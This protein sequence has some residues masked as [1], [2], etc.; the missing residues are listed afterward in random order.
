MT[1]AR[2]FGWD[3]GLDYEEWKSKLEADIRR[4]RKEGIRDI[5]NLHRLAY[6]II[7]LTQLVNGCRVGESVQAIQY[8]VKNGIPPDRK[9]RVK[10]EKRKDNYERLIVIPKIVSDRDL[11]SIVF[12]NYLDTKTLKQRVVVWAR[13]YWGINTHS[14]RYAFITHLAK[15]G[16]SAQLIGKM[17]GH[18]KLDYILYY[19]Q[20]VQAEQLLEKLVLEG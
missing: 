4:L 18:S 9:V 7:L 16:V 19:T 3:K 6:N 14:L 15:Q 12:I 20:K 17:T 1:K 5:R 2:M 10:V 8:I 13:D 11:K